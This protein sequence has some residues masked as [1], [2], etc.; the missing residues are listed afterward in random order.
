M[1]HDDNRFRPHLFRLEDRIA[2]S[3]TMHAILANLGIASIFDTSSLDSATP[4]LNVAL[5]G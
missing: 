1:G 3:D 4:P 5:G 2:A